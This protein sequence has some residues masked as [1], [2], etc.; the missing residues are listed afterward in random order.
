MKTSAPQLLRWSV[1]AAATS[2][3]I[4]VYPWLK[5]LPFPLAQLCRGIGN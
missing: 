5:F 3:S 2:V 4:G 1:T